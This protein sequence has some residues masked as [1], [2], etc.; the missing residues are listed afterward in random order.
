MH[1]KKDFVMYILRNVDPS[2]PLHAQSNIL[3]EW[4]LSKYEQGGKSEMRLAHGFLC[5]KVTEGLI[6]LLK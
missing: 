3:H 2:L 4:P 1:D 5:Q 6:E